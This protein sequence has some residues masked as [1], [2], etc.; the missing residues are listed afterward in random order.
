MEARL[1]E[2]VRAGLAA[3]ALRSAHISE[4]RD[5]WFGS[6]SPGKGK[7]KREDT[8][9]GPPRGPELRALCLRVSLTLRQGL[10]VE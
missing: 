6:I 2:V 7:Q 8:G 5:N 9:P 1:L 4:V 10:H 3:E